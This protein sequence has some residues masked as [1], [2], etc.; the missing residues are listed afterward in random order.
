MGLIATRIKTY[1]SPLP[2][3]T[4]A[5]EA[6][7]NFRRWLFC[8]WALWSGYCGAMRIAAMSFSGGSRFSVHLWFWAD[9]QLAW[10]VMGWTVESNGDQSCDLTGIIYQRAIVGGL[11]WNRYLQCHTGLFLTQYKVILQDQSYSLWGSVLFI[12]H[13]CFF[14][15]FSYNYCWG[16]VLGSRKALFMPLWSCLMF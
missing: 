15:Q 7:S 11:Q 1:D 2:P 3:R 4:I 6:P 16:F 9:A 13:C 8:K 12:T 5:P 14:L 10:W